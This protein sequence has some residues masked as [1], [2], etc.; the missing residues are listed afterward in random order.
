MALEMIDIKTLHSL[1]G[2]SGIFAFLS[3]IVYLY[4]FSQNQ[5]NK[6]SIKALIEGEGLFNA[7]QVLKIIEKFKDDDRRIDALKSLIGYERTK[8]KDLLEKIENIDISKFHAVSTKSY[9]KIA[10]RCTQFLCFLSII[11]LLA[12]WLLNHN[13][14]TVT[15][16]TN[17][18][19]SP[20]ITPPSTKIPPPETKHLPQ[21]QEVPTGEGGKLDGNIPTQSGQSRN[22][23]RDRPGYPEMVVIPAGSF[24][25]SSPKQEQ[26]RQD[27][28]SQHLVTFSKPFAIGKYEVTFN[29]YDLFAQETHRQLP[30]DDGSGR[31]TRPVINV[32][33]TDATDYVDW[34]S[35][36]TGKLYRLPTEA[37]WEYAARAG[38]SSSR[39][40][41][42]D[43]DNACIYANVYD[44]SIDL[45]NN[46]NWRHE[47]CSDG[48]AKTSPV[49]SFKANGFGLFDML[50]NV[51]EWTESCWNS[52]RTAILTND[53]PQLLDQCQERVIRGGSWKSGIETGTTVDLSFSKRQ[54][55]FPYASYPDIGFRVALT[56]N[57]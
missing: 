52:S 48:Y 44:K 39:P 54:A 46:Y 36:K 12:S 29:E 24:L 19:P 45:G 35:Q 14:A 8:A 41:G 9:E 30:G 21:G 3:L 33:W 23:F 6:Q 11:A 49:G 1:S 34:L 17:D 55:I 31:G 40:W 47:G 28:E 53:S 57:L 4:F 43:Q 5:K 16:K 32:T 13:E 38:V 50:G 51:W 18:R 15:E 20:S 42:D 10:L 26:G 7:D 27:V 22:I 2:F 37:E 56:F 25:M